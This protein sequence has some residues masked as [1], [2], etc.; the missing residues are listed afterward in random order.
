MAP[1]PAEPKP[2][3]TGITWSGVAAVVLISLWPALHG[4]Y[5]AIPLT[6]AAVTIG[7]GVWRGVVIL[8]MII[9]HLRWRDIEVPANDDLA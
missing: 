6:G 3:S 2:L 5:W 9:N 4:V 8:G 7:I 1:T